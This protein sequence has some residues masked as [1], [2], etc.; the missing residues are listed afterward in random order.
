[1][2]SPRAWWHG[3][4]GE[5]GHYLFDREGRRVGHATSPPCPFVGARWLDGGLAPRRVFD[6]HEIK[7]RVDV[8]TDRVVFTRMAPT[9]R[10]ESDMIKWHS[11]EA[12]QGVALLHR[13][14][15]ATVAAWWDRTQGDTRPGSNSC[16]IVEGDHGIDEVPHMF[17]SMFPA[18]AERLSTA[19]VT[20]RFLRW[21]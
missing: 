19:G 15:G 6:G 20:L 9:D 11:D 10:N 1:M 21:A 2:S 5:A 7:L 16:F 3:C 13:M 4:W 18:Q 12:D 8:P 14:L 17:S